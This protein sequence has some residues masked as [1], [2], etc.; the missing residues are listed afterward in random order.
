MAFPAP[1]H[2]IEAA[3]RQLGVRLLP[4]HRARLAINNGGEIVCDGDVWQLHP[5]WTT[6]IAEGPRGR[7][8]TSRMRPR[9]LAGGA[10]FRGTESP[11]PT[12]V[13]VTCWCTVPRAPASN[14]GITKP[15]SP[16]R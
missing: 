16:P 4:D 3:E 11:S 6:R 12:T 9:R 15:A 1:E 7:P 13:A 10:V 2:L 14:V 5:V 8:I